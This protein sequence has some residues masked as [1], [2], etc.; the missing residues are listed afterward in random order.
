MENIKSLKEISKVTG[1]KKSLRKV[2]K[3]VKGI[4]FVWFK[5]KSNSNMGKQNV[6]IMNGPKKLIC[7]LQR[8]I[9][10]NLKINN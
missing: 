1:T 10:L 5:A 4:L 9:M 6:L 7:I 8:N 2:I 3:K